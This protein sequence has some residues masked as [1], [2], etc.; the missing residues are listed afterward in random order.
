MEVIEQSLMDIAERAIAARFPDFRPSGR[1]PIL[2]DFGNRWEFTYE[3]PEG[4]LGGSPVVIID[5]KT[6][7]VLRIYRTQ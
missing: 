7:D 6:G 1:I 4:S 2:K 3:L 5:K